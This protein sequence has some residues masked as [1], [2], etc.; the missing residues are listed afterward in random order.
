MNILRKNKKEAADTANAANKS[1]DDVLSF[2]NDI[3]ILKNLPIEKIKEVAAK[4]KLTETLDKVLEIWNNKSVQEFITNPSNLMTLASGNKAKILA[5][6]TKFAASNP[7]LTMK[8]AGI[9]NKF[10]KLK[11][12]LNIVGN[13]GIP[14]GIPTF[15]MN[16]K[17]EEN[18]T[19]D[20]VSPNESQK[21]VQNAPLKGPDSASSQPEMSVANNDT[22][23]S[24][25]N[26]PTNGK[27]FDIDSNLNTVLYYL[28][29]FIVYVM[30][31]ITVVAVAI[32]TIYNYAIFSYYTIYEFLQS[33]DEIN[34]EKLFIRDTYSFKLLNYIF[35]QGQDM[36]SPKECGSS[37][38]GYYIE[39]LFRLFVPLDNCD[40]ES[41]VYIY[42]L[43]RFFNFCMKLFYLIFVIIFVQL[44]AY[45]II[46]TFLGGMRNYEIKGR[47]MFSY[48]NTYGALYVYIMLLI[49]LY[50][51]VHAVHF[52]FSFIDNV[53][54]RIF[55]KYE[56]FRTL[57]LYVNGEA[58][59]I[60]GDTVFLNLLKA[61][62]IYNIGKDVVVTTY[63]HK[64]KIIADIKDTD[65]PQVQSAKIFLYALYT[66]VVEHNN[67]SDI[68]IVNKLNDIV[69]QKASDGD[70]GPIKH[71]MRE[72]FKLNLDMDAVKTDLN[73]IVI[74]IGNDIAASKNNTTPKPNPVVANQF[75]GFNFETN[76]AAEDKTTVKY[77][78]ATKLSTFYRHIETSSNVNFDDVIY[79]MNMY[80]VLE[81]FINAI[82]IV[83]LLLVVYYNADQSPWIKRMV[84]S[85]SKLI[86]NIIGEIK[87][88]IIG[89]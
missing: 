28:I 16:N 26:Q 42:G 56:I 67:G 14:I 70:T 69:L 10:R 85:A 51:L 12:L 79:Y 13:I 27:S 48:L 8:I 49:F 61:S 39:Y 86:I 46:Y 4:H 17:N 76:V 38:A 53:Y 72:F 65:S 44:L 41:K 20:D 45:I 31:G 84:V 1:I 43:N 81:W 52:K 18:S 36:P 50:C 22:I 74:A 82:F 15:S 58:K 3:P 33:S 25:N 34:A 30:I 5:M 21:A 23:D 54:D 11:P 55:K 73:N 77:Y 83:L 66:Y 7:L 37:G 19:S 2:L 89:I 32:L 60:E 29:V 62:T 71:I 80:I 78:L 87:T 40:S 63:N 88:A 6:G 24:P 57:D 64:D 9:F 59:A 75:S 68:E 47:N 35:C